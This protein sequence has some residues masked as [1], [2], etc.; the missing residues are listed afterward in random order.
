MASEYPGRPKLFKGAL[1]VYESHTPGTEPE[2]LFFQYNPDS[3]RRTLARRTPPSEPG[4]AGGAREDVLR[5]AGPPVESI[6][7][8]VFLDATDQL[9]E[10]DDNDTVVEHGLHP[11]LA[12]LEMLLYAPALRVQEN[13]QLA[14]EGE[15]QVSPEELPLVLLVWGRSRVVPVQVTNFSVTE[16]AFDQNLNPI[17][18]SV[19]LGLRVLTYVELE[20]TSL[21]RDAYLSYQ[22][23]KEELAGQQRSQ[24][25]EQRTR[26]LLPGQ[27]PEGVA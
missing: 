14:E 3:V 9:A 1:A 26:A 7:L 4:S 6:N 12:A 18:A 17:R 25:D 22:R 15:V 21:G 2:L 10:P 27:S 19:E 13:E 8:T 5:A 11:A 24:G 20:S 23:N 16:E